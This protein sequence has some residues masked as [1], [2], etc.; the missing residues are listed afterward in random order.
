MLGKRKKG[1]G[2]NTIKQAEASPNARKYLDEML[3]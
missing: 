2:G 3:S 1:V